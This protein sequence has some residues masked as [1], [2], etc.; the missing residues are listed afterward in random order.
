MTKIIAGAGRPCYHSTDGQKTAAA[1]PALDRIS[2]LWLEDHCWEGIMSLSR[3]ADKIT[4]D[5][6]VH[7]VID[8]YP[9][10]VTVFVQYRLQC[11]GCYISPFHTIADVAREYALGLD[12]LLTDLNQAASA[13]T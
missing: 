1:R 2:L 5:S 8:R 13:G 6:L 11:I 4:A 12:P 3:I 7:E 9:G 10:S